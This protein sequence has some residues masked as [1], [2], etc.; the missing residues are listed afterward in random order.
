MV[1][2]LLKVNDMIRTIDVVC[3]LIYITVRRDPNVQKRIPGNLGET[4]LLCYPEVYEYMIHDKGYV[5]IGLYYS[6]TF[7]DAQKF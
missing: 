6:S 5:L 4:F 2:Y 1:E 7:C 3:I